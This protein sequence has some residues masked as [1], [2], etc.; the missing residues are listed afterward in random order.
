[1]EDERQNLEERL[2]RNIR[3]EIIIDNQMRAPICYDA[4]RML[5]KIIEIRMENQEYSRE[6]SSYRAGGDE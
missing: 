4:E 6:D 2:R 5:D 1:M 3:R